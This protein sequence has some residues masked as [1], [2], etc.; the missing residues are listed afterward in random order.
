MTRDELE[1]E[2]LRLAGIGELDKIQRILRSRRDGVPREVVRE[3]VQEAC[4]AVVQ[5]QQDGGRITNVAGLIM[6]IA[7]RL[8]T[9]TWD[10]MM[11]GYEVDAAFVRRQRGVGDWRHDEQWQARIERGVE[12][13]FKAV[14]NWPADNHRR[15]MMAMIDAATDGVQL[16]PTDLDHI[17]GCAPGTGRVWRDRAFDRLRVQIEK[18]GMSW[19][20]ITQLLPGFGGGAHIDE[21]H[22]VMDEDDE[23]DA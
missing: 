19:D 6:T 3:V 17:L 1:A 5:R 10:E 7:D 12:Y 9:D 16:R 8:L 23:E 13:V 14:A 15:T 18:D 4:L 2:F 11:K 22:F 21:E 20:D